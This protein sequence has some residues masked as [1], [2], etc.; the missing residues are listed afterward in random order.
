MG[1]DM[2]LLNH[3]ERFVKGLP[4]AYYRDILREFHY[5]EIVKHS[6]YTPRIMEFVTRKYN[7]KKGAQ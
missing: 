5:R 6:N 1:R 2:E 3:S 7:F 4:A